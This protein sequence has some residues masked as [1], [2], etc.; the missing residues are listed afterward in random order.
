MASQSQEYHNRTSCNIVCSHHLDRENPNA[1]LTVS[2]ENVATATKRT[3]NNAGQHRLHVTHTEARRGH[4]HR[5]MPL[6]SFHLA[7]TVKSTRLYRTDE[8]EHKRDQSSNFTLQHNNGPIPSLCSISDENN[9]DR[10]GQWCPSIGTESVATKMT[11][12]KSCCMRTCLLVCINFAP[13]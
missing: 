9:G 5:P 10:V 1:W 7:A 4:Q 13:R 6:W 8:L 11:R 3:A 2:C 12:S